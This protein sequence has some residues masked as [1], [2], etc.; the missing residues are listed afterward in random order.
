MGKPSEITG[1]VGGITGLYTRTFGMSRASTECLKAMNS[2]RLP[3][4]GAMLPAARKV[5]QV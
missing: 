1:Q 3:R 4:A 2:A 5:M